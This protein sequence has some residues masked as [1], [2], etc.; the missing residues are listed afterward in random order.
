MECTGTVTLKK[1]CEKRINFID[2]FR[3]NYYYMIINKRE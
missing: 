2:I 3:E 1:L